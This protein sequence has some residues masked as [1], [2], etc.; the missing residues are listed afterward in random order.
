MPKHKYTYEDSQIPINTFKYIIILKICHISSIGTYQC[1]NQCN[2]SNQWMQ[3]I[4]VHFIKTIHANATNKHQY[5]QVH[6]NTAYQPITIN[7]YF[8]FHYI[9]L[10]SI[11]ADNEI[12]A[13]RH[14]HIPIHANTYQYM[15]YIPYVQYKKYIQIC[16]NTD[17]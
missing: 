8:T 16:S 6:T 1:C 13:N 14:M 12:H 10:L 9:P 4:Q 5:I 2:A 7:L 11:H 3:Y 17:H 15:Q